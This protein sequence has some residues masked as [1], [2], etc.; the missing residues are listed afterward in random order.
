MQ[1]CIVY[2]G[3]VW[4]NYL[5]KVQSAGQGSEFEPFSRHLNRNKDIWNRNK[6]RTDWF[7]ST[8]YSVGMYVRFS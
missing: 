6:Q 5:Q 1:R 3:T 7:L 4:S 2:V 8:N